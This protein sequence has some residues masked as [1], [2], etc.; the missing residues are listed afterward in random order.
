MD[1]LL[2][3][4]RPAGVP[5]IEDAAHAHGALRHGRRAGAFADLACFS[6]YPTKNL[7]AAGD[8]GAVVTAA[9]ELAARCRQLAQ[10]GWS[11]R[12]HAELPGGRNSRLD[13][14]Q[15]AVLRVKLP[16][17]DNWN[18]RRRQIA[19]FYENGLRGVPGLSFQPRGDDDDTVHLFVIECDNRTAVQMAL[20]EAGVATGAH[21]PVADHQQRAFRDVHRAGQ[22]PV[23]EALCARVLSLPC[24]PEIRDDEVYGVVS[25]LQKHLSHG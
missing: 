20:K 2:S 19:E 6:F 5:V 7:G 22:L 9:D 8:A 12:N 25:A 13:E 17:L 10:Y 3:I 21:Y 16:Y 11:E 23:T 4:T 1:D 15:A 24:Y 14:I 18:K